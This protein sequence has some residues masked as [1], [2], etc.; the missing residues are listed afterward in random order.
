MS[1]PQPALEKQ[2][3]Q[4]HQEK[5]ALFRV[6]HADGVWW[7]VNPWNNLHLAFY[8]ERAPIAQKVYYGLN[9][10]G[11]WV[12]MPEE[13]EGKKGWFREMEVDVS[14]SL[15]GAYAVL[16]AIQGYIKHMET[17]GPQP[18]QSQK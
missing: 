11:N 13:R 8:S 7:S 12:E 9:A 4:V 10:E 2:R 1:D 16:D 5:S 14:L 3:V 18:D 6:V 17:I 15:N